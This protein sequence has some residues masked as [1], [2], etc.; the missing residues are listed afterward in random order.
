MRVGIIF[1]A[2]AAGFGEESFESAIGMYSLP[3]FFMR[4]IAPSLARS[5]SLE[6]I[7]SCGASP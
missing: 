4:D 6:A 2:V 7:V 5:L 3:Q 1:Y